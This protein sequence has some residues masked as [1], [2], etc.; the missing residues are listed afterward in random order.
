MREFP[1]AERNRGR[2]ILLASSDLSELL[3]LSDR[4]A[5]MSKAPGT[6]E[7]V[8]ENDLKRPRNLRAKEFFAYEDHLSNL[9]KR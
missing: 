6:V 2:G 3:E 7:K 8:L 5:V 1:I 4:I 9:I